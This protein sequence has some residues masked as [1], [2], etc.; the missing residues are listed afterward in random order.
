[1]KTNLQ[2]YALPLA[3]AFVAVFSIL[4]ASIES[5]SAVFNQTQINIY[6]SFKASDPQST[7]IININGKQIEIPKS[8]SNSDPG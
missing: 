5:R 8:I 6:K 7:E 3:L 1:M 2:G 4:I